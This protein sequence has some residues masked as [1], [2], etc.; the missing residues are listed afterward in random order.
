LFAF[1]LFPL[2]SRFYVIPQWLLFFAGQCVMF[3][4]GGCSIL[5]PVSLVERSW[6]WGALYL[7]FFFP[8]EDSVSSRDCEAGVSFSSWRLLAVGFS[9]FLIWPFLAVF[10]VWCF[11][12]GLRLPP[13]LGS[14]VSFI[15]LLYRFFRCP[16]KSFLS[17]FFA[18]FFFFS[19]VPDVPLFDLGRVLIFFFFFGFCDLCFVTYGRGAASHLSQYRPREPRP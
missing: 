12:F 17:A 9:Y 1:D 19:R 10:S 15:L 16:D 18:A 8:P 14:R 6:F 11:A 3:F 2:I 5:L 4:P 7:F 13:F